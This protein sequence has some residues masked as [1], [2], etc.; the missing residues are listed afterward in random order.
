[1]ANTEKKEK[2]KKKSLLQEFQEFIARGDVIELA[3][4][5]TVGVAFTTLISSLVNNIVMPPIG[6]IL[7]G[8]SFA[9]LYLNLSGTAYESLAAAE[10][11]GAPVLKYGQ[12]LSDL[13]NFLII[14][15]VIFFVI[16]AIT[17][18]RLRMGLTESGSEK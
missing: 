10:E 8:E 7:N 11:A 3:V 15:I 5:L 6:L 13:T 1:M 9:D 12:F 4:G 17:A 14:A 18:L 16:K 2:S